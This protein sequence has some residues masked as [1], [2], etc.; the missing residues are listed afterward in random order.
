MLVAS[1]I[2]ILCILAFTQSFFLTT[3]VV[4]AIFFGI[5]N[6]YALYTFVFGINFFPFMNVLAVIISVGVGADDCFI[7]VKSWTMFSRRKSDPGLG[8][9]DSEDYLQRLV[10]QTMANCT[11]S[12]IVTSATT[13]VAFF[14]SFVSSITAI[15]CFRLVSRSLNVVSFDFVS[16]SSLPSVFAGFAILSNLV[17]M[18]TWVP[19]SLAFYQK[20]C[21]ASCCCCLKTY[22]LNERGDEIEELVRQDEL[23]IPSIILDH[24]LSIQ[25][26]CHLG[27]LICQSRAKIN[28]KCRSF[29][30]KILPKVVVKLRNVSIG[31]IGLIILASTVAVFYKPGLTLP[32]QENFQLFKK[33]H[34]FERYDPSTSS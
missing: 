26:S 2:I 18:L 15:K 32:E 34:D 1:I 19:A 33:E 30:E 3:A 12:M 6:A 7:L 27:R 13:A 8:P 14:A 29:F 10:R 9:H 28:K 4:L 22:K 24:H 16:L 5:A 25:D 21:H 23:F 31:F 20:Y 17:L 11:L